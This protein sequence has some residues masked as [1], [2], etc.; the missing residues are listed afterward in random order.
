MVHV[1]V[2]SL[3]PSYTLSDNDVNKLIPPFRKYNVMTSLSPSYTLS[4]SL[5]TLLC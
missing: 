2:T 4:D 1:V 5:I 3:G